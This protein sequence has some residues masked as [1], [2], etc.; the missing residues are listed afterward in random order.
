MPMGPATNSLNRC[1]RSLI[2]RRLAVARKEGAIFSAAV[3]W[4]PWATAFGT[5]GNSECASSLA[6]GG[7]SAIFLVADWLFSAGITERKILLKSCCNEKSFW[8]IPRSVSQ[9][10]ER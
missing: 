10:R 3:G 7:F 4:V 2:R 8:Y 6:S 5:I 1:W 9:I